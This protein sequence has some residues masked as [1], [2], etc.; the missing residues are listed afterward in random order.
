MTGVKEFEQQDVPKKKIELSIEVSETGEVS[1]HIPKNLE[2]T[3][4]LATIL[5]VLIHDMNRMQ[6]KQ[7]LSP[8]KPNI[9]TSLKGSPIMQ[10]IFK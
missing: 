8:N 1:W 3:N 10:R 2:I 6:L 4:H 7:A 5:T 9:I